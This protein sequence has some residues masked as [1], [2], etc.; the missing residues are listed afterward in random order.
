[1][2]HGGQYGLDVAVRG[3]GENLENAGHWRQDLALEGLA[4]ELHDRL[5]EVG[6]VAYRLIFDPAVLAIAVTQQMGAIG[7]ALVVSGG[8]DDVNS[9]ASARHKFLIADLCGDVKRF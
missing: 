4:N 2:A 9:Q 6:E 7:P 1:M 8:S 5:R 3:R